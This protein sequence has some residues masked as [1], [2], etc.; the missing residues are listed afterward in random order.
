MTCEGSDRGVLLS[1]SA[2]SFVHWYSVVNIDFATTPL[3]PHWVLFRTRI[4]ENGGRN[5]TLLVPEDGGATAWLSGP[6]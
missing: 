1:L 5:D 4:D 6:C 3:D 2:P